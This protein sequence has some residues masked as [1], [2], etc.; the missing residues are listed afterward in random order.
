MKKIIFA[1]IVVLTCSLGGVAGLLLSVP[2]WKGII[3][4][5]VGCVLMTIISIV[6]EYIL[7]KLD[8]QTK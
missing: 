6:Y 5:I 8:E 4:S 2:L 7:M 1:L 3:I